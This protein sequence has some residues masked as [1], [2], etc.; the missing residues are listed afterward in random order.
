MAIRERKGFP[1]PFES[2]F[3]VH[4]EITAFVPS[5]D[6]YP[7]DERDVIIHDITWHGVSVYELLKQS[8][9]LAR[10]EQDFRDDLGI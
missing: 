2:N 3:D 7:G 8:N 9:Q 4:Y 5:S 1:F 10:F 6:D